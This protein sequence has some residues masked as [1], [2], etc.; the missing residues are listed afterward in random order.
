MAKI[1]N[2]SAYPLQTAANVEL[3]DMVIITEDRTLETKNLKLSTLLGLQTGIVTFKEQT[4]VITAAEMLDLNVNPVTLVGAKGGDTFIM[5]LTI[6][7]KL[8]Y[9]SVAF[10]FTPGQFVSI[11]TGDWAALAGYFTRVD[12]SFFNTA[13]TVLTG[14]VIGVNAL[15]AINIGNPNS[16]LLFYGTGNTT[17]TVGDSTATVTVQYTTIKIT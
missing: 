7:I 17:A 1:S 11:T 9:N 6:M 2:T 13:A 15:P 5:P 16:P 14:G 10:D 12:T 4:T 3:D 8:D